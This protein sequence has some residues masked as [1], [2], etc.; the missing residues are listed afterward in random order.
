MELRYPIF[1]F[2]SK[3]KKSLRLTS[4]KM[5][6]C[7]YVVWVNYITS[8]H[9]KVAHSLPTYQGRVRTIGGLFV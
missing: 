6:H 3:S 9:S 4:S 8:N 2:N 1:V 7:T 5:M